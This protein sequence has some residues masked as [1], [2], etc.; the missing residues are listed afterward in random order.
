MTFG[1]T[2]SNDREVRSIRL[3][4]DVPPHSKVWLLCAAISASEAP[5]LADGSGT[6]LAFLMQASYP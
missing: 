6:S 2:K 1:P 3:S 5:P 4:S